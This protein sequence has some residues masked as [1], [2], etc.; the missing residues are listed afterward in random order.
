MVVEGKTGEWQ[1]VVEQWY[2]FY[3]LVSIWYRVG[4][5]MSSAEEAARTVL[6]V[7]QLRAEKVETISAIHREETVM[8]GIIAGFGK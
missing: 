3:S 1:D 2:V 7:G 4:G 6:S 8:A 5:V